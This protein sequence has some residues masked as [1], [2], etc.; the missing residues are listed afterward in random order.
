MP[1]WIRGMLARPNEP[2]TPLARYTT[3]NGVLY[4]VLGLQLY[5]WPGVVQVFFMADPFEAGEAGLLRAMG[6]CVA[7]IGWFYIFGSRTN[8]DSF[9]LATIGDRLLVP[10]FLLPL[11]W[12]G[13]VDPMIVVPLAVLDPL[14]AFGAWLI[15]KR[16]DPYSPPK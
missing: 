2:V 5:F 16:T 10:L 9:G 11:A 6:L 4:I 15:W 13:E 8:R 7:I 14:L 1:A 3:W 12:T